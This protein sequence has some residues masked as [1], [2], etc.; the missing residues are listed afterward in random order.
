MPAT[1]RWRTERRN[2]EERVRR[3]KGGDDGA[4]GATCPRIAM[5]AA[6]P[7]HV[8]FTRRRQLNANPPARNANAKET[9]G[10]GRGMWGGGRWGGVGI[11]GGVCGEVSYPRGSPTARQ[12]GNGNASRESAAR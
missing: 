6:M 3:I 10:G 11:Q 8:F 5:P 1:L 7:Q 4:V 9:R 12:V 2:G